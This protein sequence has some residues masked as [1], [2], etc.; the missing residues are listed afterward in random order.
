MSRTIRRASILAAAA[1]AAGGLAFAGPALA[2]NASVQPQAGLAFYQFD[3]KGQTVPLQENAGCTEL[4]EDTQEGTTFPMGSG[5]VTDGK[6]TITFYAS[7][8]CSPTSVTGVATPGNPA[9]YLEL[10]GALSYTSTTPS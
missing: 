1:T 2:A 3:L 7:L 6:S 10:V 5:E 8:D 4:T 9:D